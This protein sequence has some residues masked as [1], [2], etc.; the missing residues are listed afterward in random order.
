MRTLQGQLQEKG[1]AKETEP[2]KEEGR[3]KEQL[4]GKDLAELMNSNAP[5]YKRS[6]GGAI[7]RNR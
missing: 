3:P 7:R 5:T 6:K 2:M 1:L 4:S